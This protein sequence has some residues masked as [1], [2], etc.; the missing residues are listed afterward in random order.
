MSKFWNQIKA[1]AWK[2]LLIRYRNIFTLLFEI[3]IPVGV[4]IGMWGIRL[5]LNPKLTKMSIPDYAYQINSLGFYYYSPPFYGGENPLWYCTSS[6]CNNRDFNLI[7]Y[8]E[9]EECYSKCQLK[10]I[11]VAPQNEN[12][13][14][15]S[16]A[17]DFINYTS[18]IP[19]TGWVPTPLADNNFTIPDDLFVFFESESSFTDYITSAKYSIDPDYYIYTAAIVFNSASPSWDYTIRTNKTYN[20]DGYTTPETQISPI[21]SQLKT[22]GD[23]PSS[24]TGESMEPYLLAYM[25]LGVYAIQE[26]VHNYIGTRTCQEAG[27]C[28]TDNVVE[29]F[30]MGIADFPNPSN[31]SDIFWSA[32]GDSFALLMILA[33]LYPIA[34]VI[35]TLVTEKETKLRE[36]MLMMALKPEALWTAWMIHFLIFFIPLAVILM[37]VGQ[38]LFVYSEQVYIFLYFL[39]FFLASI[40]YAVL[41]SVVFDK[42]KT[43]AIVGVLVFFVGY[44]VYIGIGASNVS[45][46]TLLLACLHPASAFTYGILAFVEYE[47][48]KVGI[49]SYTWRTSELYSI[50][51]RDTIVMQAV[52]MAWLLGLAWYLAQVILLFAY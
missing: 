35:R 40:S 23:N 12:D 3:V 15:T 42:A 41:V 9:F 1:L 44:F 24:S 13:D 51:F 31:L 50:S 48:S 2:N 8:E 20:D 11:A 45:R 52:N 30:P 27:L 49:S 16:I 43:A 28:G 17:K 5:A 33:L 29:Y 19:Y 7:T 39:M 37:L 18:S 21:N 6:S 38:L 34:N 36:G 14:L 47:D 46:S 4:L 10:R 26:L 25:N 32:I 22:N